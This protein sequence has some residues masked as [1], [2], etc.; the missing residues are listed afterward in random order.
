MW[1]VCPRF[2]VAG[3]FVI[4]DKPSVLLLVVCRNRELAGLW[5][6]GGLAGHVGKQLNFDSPVFGAP[7]SGRVWCDFLILANTDQIKLVRR[8][9]VLRGQILNHGLGTALAEIVVIG[10]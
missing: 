8:H 9:V 6:G 4:P 1:S 10:G 2:S 3:A 7:G 5:S